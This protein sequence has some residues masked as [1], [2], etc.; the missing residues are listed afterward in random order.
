MFSLDSQETLNVYIFMAAILNLKF[1]FIG[2]YGRE[3]VIEQPFM[4]GYILEGGS[5]QPTKT[6]TKGNLF[7]K[8]T[9]F[10]QYAL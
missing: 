8:N 7:Y 4:K 10:N 5:T 3:I 2:I 6:Q 9:D 1:L